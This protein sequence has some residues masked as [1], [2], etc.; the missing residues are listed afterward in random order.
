MSQNAN[1]TSDASMEADPR[2]FQAVQYVLGELSANDHAAFEASLVDDFSLCELVAEA[3]RLTQGVQLALA[4]PVT[5]AVTVETRRDRWFVAAVATLTAGIAAGLLA[6]LSAPVP[7]TPNQ[8]A[9]LVSL[10]RDAGRT[11]TASSFSAAGID[12][13][14]EESNDDRVPN[15]MLAAVSLEHRPNRQPL[16]GNA[17][18]EPWE[19]N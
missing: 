18:L 6:T 7:R 14:D 13:D 3:T 17:P 1:L 10:W 12:T 11:N 19:D 15:W 2:F 5:P 4:A 8:A 9:K 16:P